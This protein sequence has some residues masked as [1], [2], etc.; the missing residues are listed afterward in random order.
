MSEKQD[1]PA[2]SR[3]PD[4]SL[5]S[6]MSN[7]V[8]EKGGINLAQGIPGFPPPEGLLDMLRSLAGEPIHQYAPGTG[9][10]ELREVILDHYQHD[11]PYTQDHLLV[12]N[13]AT[14]AISL[15]YTYLRKKRGRPMRV[16]ALDPA[17]ES[18]RQLPRIFGDEFLPVPW[19][20]GTDTSGLEQLVRR[21]QPDLVFLNSPGNPM[22]AVLDRE[23]ILEWSGL[24]EKFGFHIL[25]DAVYRD[26]YFDTP[27]YIPS[28]QC[29]PGLF[30]INSFSKTLSITGWRVGYLLSHPSHQKAL[31]DIHDY[32]G[33][34]SPAPLQKAIARYL[35]EQAFG[36]AYIRQ[37][38]EKLS[39]NHT[40]LSGALASR[41]F[42]IPALAG[43]YFLWARLPQGEGLDFAL[44]LYGK[45]KVAVVPGIHFSPEGRDWIRL[46][47]AREHEEV[48]EGITRI[49]RFLDQA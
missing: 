36:E 25:F 12:V 29:H 11:Y 10:L 47:M 6:H 7:L 26:L 31:R 37:V 27:P 32:I 14:E 41:G 43:G 48:T 40:T 46:N 24:S 16:V 20:S 22:G 15:I 23:C 5:I 35:K 13:G 4:G 39:L 28:D 34:S 21:I 30:Y 17:Y 49:N 9:D 33:L 3:I 42:Q 18:Y 1:S 8:K 38:R 2:R 19:S 44:D 45:E